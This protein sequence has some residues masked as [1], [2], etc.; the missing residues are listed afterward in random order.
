MRMENFSTPTQEGV[1]LCL[2]RLPRMTIRPATPADQAALLAL[3]QA[4]AQDP[5]GIARMP[6]EI[7]DAYIAS[8]LNLQPPVGLQRVVTDEAGELMG[9]IHGERYRLRIFTHILTG[10]TVVVHPRHQGRGIGKA[11]FSQFLRDVRQAFPDIRR[12][13]LEA[14]ATNEASLRLYESLGF[15][16]E[17]V[18]RNKTRNRDGSFVDSVAMALTFTESDRY[19]R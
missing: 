12:V 10:I 13:E 1:I 17:G 5:N 8:L 15:E 7:T 4:V 18:Y 14:R 9:E 3:H 11:L 6:D 19:S 2:L 16:R